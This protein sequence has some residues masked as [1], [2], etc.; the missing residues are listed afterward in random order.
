M[1]PL[2]IG[3]ILLII[4]AVA[5]SAVIDNKPQSTITVQP[6]EQVVSVTPTPQQETSTPEVKGEQSQE[7]LVI[8]VID[9]DT[10]EIEGGRKV[11]YIGIDTAETVHPNEPVGCFGY[12]ASNKNKELVLNKKVKLEKDV[13]E[14]D[15]YGRFL[16]YV[17]VGNVFVNEY[18]VKEG[19]AQSS[20]YPPDV[21]YQDLFLQAQKEARENNKGL[22]RVCSNSEE[23]EIKPI[24]TQAPVQSTN[25][26]QGNSYNCSE[27]TYNCSDFQYQEDAQYVFEY[28][29]GLSNDIHRLDGD[30]DGIVCES[31][32]K[33]G[34]GSE[35]SSQPKT[36]TPIQKT[37]PPPQTSNSGEY[38]CSCSKTCTEMSSCDEAYYQLNQCGCSKR[39]GDKDGVPCESICPGG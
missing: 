13:S 35:T 6:Q 12:E 11:R 26:P 15:K 5:G 17:W 31:L 14:T 22:W 38:S 7:V 20:T 29:G 9:G 34:S 10:I 30:K 32:S 24:S 3:L 36:Q 27:N 28:C 1:P 19:Y 37:Q 4:G 33:K 8:R 16:R 23:A 25:T 21:K 2:I 39:D 18:L